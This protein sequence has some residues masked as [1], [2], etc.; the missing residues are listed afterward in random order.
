MLNSSLHTYRLGCYAYLG[1]SLRGTGSRGARGSCMGFD[2]CRATRQCREYT[3][4][5]PG[6]TC[7]RS[8]HAR[9][10]PEQRGKPHMPPQQPH[11]QV[12][13]RS[14]TDASTSSPAHQ[15]PAY[16]FNSGDEH[17]QK[18]T[19]EHIFGDGGGGGAGVA[20]TSGS[21]SPSAGTGRRPSAPWALGW[22]MS[23]RNLVW[24]DELKLRLIKVRSSCACVCSGGGGGGAVEWNPMVAMHAAPVLTGR[25]A[26]LVPARS[27][28]RRCSG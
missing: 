24:N 26:G 1:P 18:A 6:A 7:V 23:E 5:C 16:P 8:R 13:A 12:A 19:I 14:G 20:S 2:A 25:P 28:V 21:S 17:R 9:H 27:A 11:C 22:Q 3:T 4:A 15:P 10:A